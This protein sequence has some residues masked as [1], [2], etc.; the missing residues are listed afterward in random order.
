MKHHGRLPFLCQVIN[1]DVHSD[2]DDQ[3]QSFRAVVRLVQVVKKCDAM[4]AD[5]QCCALNTLY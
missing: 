2:A 3:R 5:D 1:V 4:I